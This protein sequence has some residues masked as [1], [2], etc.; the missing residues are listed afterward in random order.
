MTDSSSRHACSNRA[1]AAFKVGTAVRSLTL[2]VKLQKSCSK[3][4]LHSTKLLHLQICHL[5]TL[6]A[7]TTW[8]EELVQT[9]LL[10][11]VKLLLHL[12]SRL[13]QVRAQHVAD[14]LDEIGLYKICAAVDQA[15]KL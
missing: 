14:E 6:E 11:L 13:F 12:H 5:V 4:A 15:R 2:G 7:A 1:A 10:E 9:P 3:H 8:H